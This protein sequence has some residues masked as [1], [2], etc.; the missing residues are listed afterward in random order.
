MDKR[1]KK[2][3]NDIERAI[4]DAYYVKLTSG[5]LTITD[6]VKTIRKMSKLTQ[7]EFAKHRGISIG[8]LKQIESGKG[9]PEVNTLNKIV[10]IM[11]IEVG[12]VLKQKNNL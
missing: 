1:I 4:R 12:F 10:E 8:A 9:N 5:K 7:A 3:D 11:G 2:I 6:G